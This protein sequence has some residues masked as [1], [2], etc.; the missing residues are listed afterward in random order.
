MA[1]PITYALQIPNQL[2]NL[3][4]DDFTKITKDA[5]AEARSSY[6]VPKIMR[7][8][9]VETILQSVLVGDKNVSFS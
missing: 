2:N 4:P 8:K 7:S 3:S 5:L 1:T 6:A 9:H